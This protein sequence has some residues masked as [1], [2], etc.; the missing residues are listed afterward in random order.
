[1]DFPSLLFYR[2]TVV[3]DQDFQVMSYHSM[4]VTDVVHFDYHWSFLNYLWWYGLYCFLS[5]GQGREDGLVVAHIHHKVLD[6]EC[7]RI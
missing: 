4:G 6:F 7:K 3:F 2:L 5:V 1:M